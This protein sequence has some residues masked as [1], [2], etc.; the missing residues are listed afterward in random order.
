MPDPRTVRVAVVQAAP[1]LF[2][3]AAGTDKACRLV[4]EAAANGA[5]LV[6]LPEAYLPGYPRG[7]GFGTLVGGRTPAGRDL[8]RGDWGGAGPGPGPPTQ[9]PGAPPP[10]AQPL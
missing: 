1:A 6:L 9:T 7:L 3:R 8:W 2:D 10:E 4:R 5:R